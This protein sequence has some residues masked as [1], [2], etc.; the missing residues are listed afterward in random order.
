V[1]SDDEDLPS[2]LGVSLEC[3]SLLVGLWTYEIKKER[4]ELIDELRTSLVNQHVSI[5]GPVEELVQD[6]GSEV[7]MASVL[8]HVK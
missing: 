3:L 8:E 7:Y 1:P 6:G 5:E 2:Q 4:V